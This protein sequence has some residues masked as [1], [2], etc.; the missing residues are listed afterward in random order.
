MLEGRPLIAHAA[1]AIAPF[2]GEIVVCGT[3]GATTGDRSDSLRHPRAGGS[4]AVIASEE[5]GPRLR[6]NDGEWK[7]L[8]DLPHAGLGPL[9]GIAAALDYAGRHGFEA[10][11]TIACDMPRVPAALIE[12]LTQ[13]RPSCCADAPILGCWPAALFEDLAAHLQAAATEAG[14]RR[15]IRRWAQ[16]IGATAVD[17]AAGLPNINTP[18]DLLAL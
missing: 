1:T 2:V 14:T 6:R 3:R 16:A 7:V 17:A 5:Q 18:A 9:G 4:P 10:V 12:R 11:L 8:P 13:A 15:S